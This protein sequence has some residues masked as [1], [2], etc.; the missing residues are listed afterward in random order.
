MLHDVPSNPI[1]EHG[2][3]CCPSEL[4]DSAPPLLPGVASGSVLDAIIHATM[5][6]HCP[7]GSWQFRRHSR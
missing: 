7:V 4:R 1:G 6:R 5:H 3:P 2:Q